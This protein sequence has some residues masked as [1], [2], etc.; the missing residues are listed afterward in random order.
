M[1][2]HL[3][4]IFLITTLSTT[5]VGLV[6]KDGFLF[7]DIPPVSILFSGSTSGRDPEA[8]YYVTITNTCDET[9]HDVT[10]SRVID[11]RVKNIVVAPT[12]PP[13]KYSTLSSS[14]GYGRGIDFIR[15][16][17][18]TGPNSGLTVTCKGFSKPLPVNGWWEGKEEE[19]FQSFLVAAKEGDADAQF[20]IGFSYCFGRGMIWDATE[21]INWS[22]KAANS[23]NYEAMRLLCY[24][25]A[26]QG[27]PRRAELEEDLVESMKWMLILA[28]QKQEPPEEIKAVLENKITEKQIEEAQ[29][30]ANEWTSPATKYIRQSLLPQK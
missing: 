25:Y 29:K 24:V 1:Y 16:M 28:R 14:R 3:L 7:N 27:G 12:I 15:Q 4:K 6:A 2:N 26:G 5:P 22:L 30:L 19:E 9:I 10:L 13:H 23:G 11:G 18:L 8:N 21:G 17:G 20:R